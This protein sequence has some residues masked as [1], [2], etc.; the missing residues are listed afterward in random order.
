MTPGFAH[1]RIKNQVTAVNIVH[2]R[3]HQGLVFSASFLNLTVPVDAFRNI[4][5]R[6]SVAL[7]AH[8][9]ITLAAGA[10]ATLHIYEGPTVT[11]NGTPIPSINRNRNSTYEAASLVFDG[12]VVTDDGFELDSHFTAGGSG[13]HATGGTDISFNEWIFK[14]NTDYL[15]RP[16][17]ISGKIIGANLRLDFYEPL[18]GH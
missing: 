9:R 2:E 6:T 8:V 7:E 5:F 15:I 16:T 11:D 12:A 10:E 13:P 1:S 14:A 17:N 3:I 4:L 18:G